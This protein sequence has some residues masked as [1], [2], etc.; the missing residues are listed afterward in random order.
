MKQ[1]SASDIKKFLESVQFLLLIPHGRA[2]SFFMQSLL[3]GHEE[4]ISF[5]S[6]FSDYAFDLGDDRSPQEISGE[7]CA[8][9]PEFFSSEGAYI[10]Q[11]G[12]VSQSLLGDKKNEHIAVDREIFR[13]QLTHII[14][15][16]KACKML[17]RKNYVLGMH[18][19]LAIT[20]NRDITKIRY[21][22]YHLHGGMCYAPR[23]DE[24]LSD[25]PGLYFIAMTRD[26]RESWVSFNLV[27]EK[28]WGK[29]KYFSYFVRF[30]YQYLRLY[31]DLV[32]YMRRFLPG[33]VFIL[34]LNQL[35]IEQA[36]AMKRLSRWLGIQ[37]TD[38]LCRSTFLGKTWWG[39]AANAKPM[40]GFCI[41][42]SE[43]MWKNKMDKK[44]CEMVEYLMQP[45]FEVF[46]HEKPKSVIGPATY[47]ARLA[48][49]RP[50]FNWPRRQSL[51][52]D[53]VRKGNMPLI[54]PFLSRLPAYRKPIMMRCYFSLYLIAQ[55]A[56][57]FFR[58]L[59]PKDV[60]YFEK[61][62]RAKQTCILRNV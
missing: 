46:G 60:I 53:K 44:E 43:F 19:A 24:M 31:Y 61:S 36:E 7:F 62:R 3:D 27:L 21:V 13:A 20:L 59:L 29:Q 8:R 14:E 49:S 55:S 45:L 58:R 34:D 42:K 48:F 10:A 5:P 37:Y 17:T 12:W 51:L 40:S 11:E 41:S 18:L 33:H 30:L 54:V 26:I 57:F 16:L 25:F 56:L 38:N 52:V 22:L 35:H 47:Y 50:L 4:I 1:C 9:Y 6:Y 2:G 23:V 39:N 28:R 15:Y 32:D